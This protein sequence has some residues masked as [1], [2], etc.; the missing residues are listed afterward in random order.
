MDTLG[1]MQ[2]SDGLHQRVITDRIPVNGTIEVTRR[3]PLTCIHCYNRL[4]MGDREA[5]R[6]ELTYEE[7][8]RILDEITEAGC[9]WLLYTGGEI[10]AREDFLRIYT[11]AKQKG[12]I[13]SLFTNGTLITPS[14][15]DYLAEWRPFS[16][17][18]TLYGRTQATYER[19]TGIPGSYARCMRGIYLLIERGLPLKLKTMAVT[20]NKHEVWEMKQFAEE[21]LGVEFSFD[22]MVNPR[23][24][25]SHSP[26]AVRLSPAEIVEMDLRDPKRVAAWRKLTKSAAGCTDASDCSANLYDC[27]GGITSF[28]VDPQGRLS[29]CVLSRQDTIDLRAETFREAWDNLH[30][31]VRCRIRA[32]QT[33]C[34][35]CPLSMMCDMCPANGELEHRDPELPV[36]F[37]CQTAHL[38]AYALGLPMEAHGRCEYCPGGSKSSEMMAI[39]ASLRIECEGIDAPVPR[40]VH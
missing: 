7:H 20:L 35:T 37:L 2:F 8:C 12:L 34:V 15:A 29:L 19:L 17:E 13:V 3:C 26:L 4:P 31:A 30:A 6:D 39:V 11:Y 24:D 23:I 28:A 18:I 33:K 5:R 9:L 10:F 40:Y 22:P 38:R 36:D 1:Y 14:V 32:R 16:I 21:E 27:G 25:C